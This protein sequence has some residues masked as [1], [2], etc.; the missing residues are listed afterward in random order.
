MLY[1]DNAATSFPKPVQVR[2]AVCK[3][4]ESFGNPSR[5]AHELALNAARCVEYA[6]VQVSELFGCRSS[7]RVAFTA[8]VTE[9]LNIAISSVKGHIVTSATEHNSVL[10]PVYRSGS[11][12]V[13]PVDEYGRYSPGD[14]A[15]ALQ[16]DTRAVVLGHASNLTGQINPIRE[17][18]QLCREKKLIF[19]VDAAQTAGLLE[20]DM[21]RMGIDALCFTGHKSLYGPQ[22]TGGICLSERF[23][24]AP[25]LVGGSGSHSFD[26]EHPAAMPSRLEAGTVNGHGLAGLSAGLEYIKAQGVEKLL[27]A[28]DKTARHFYQ[29]IKDLGG[30]VLY[31]HYGDEPRM[32][33]VTLNVGE[34]AADEVAAILAEEYDIAV[35]PGAHCAPLLHE[36]FGTV[37]RG[38]VRFS[39]S[40]FNTIEEADAAIAAIRDIAGR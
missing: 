8:N 9:A 1:F 23:L 30:I 13:V 38:S 21:E 27:A 16:P 37:R 11:Y 2:E 32:P 36:A 14:I 10:R 31:G 3:A 17:V 22:G 24:P 19:I 15:K 5:S 33:I 39:F 18:G 29:G 20:I 40:H 35:R 12:S 4:L 26:R 25:L 28:A 34:L 6:R 7:E